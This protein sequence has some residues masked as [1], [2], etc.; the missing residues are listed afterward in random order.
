MSLKVKNILIVFVISLFVSC[1]S[2]FVTI[3]FVMKK[4]DVKKL[5][6]QNEVNL[7]D[8]G[9]GIMYNSNQ[10]GYNNS[11][12]D[13]TVDNTQG[14]IDQLYSAANTFTTYD[15]RLQTVED[16]IGSSSLNT[17]SQ[18]LSDAI[19]ELN[20]DLTVV[21]TNITGCSASSGTILSAVER[22]YGKLTFVK[23]SISN[24][25]KARFTVT[26]PQNW[27][28]LYSYSI[29]GNKNSSD[30][31]YTTALS[32]GVWYNAPT[33]SSHILTFDGAFADGHTASF[34]GSNIN[35]I[36]FDAIFIY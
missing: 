31:D 36:L 5:S 26:C 16:K 6:S 8:V 17:T 32:M 14:A 4:D 3:N 12:T 1:V 11:N 10:V 7:G 22:K 15:T 23:I 2:I 33:N 30:T 28:Y 29:R 13:I 21:T 20:S 27:G 25:P 19:N 9:G 34:N 35:I 24:A 18:N